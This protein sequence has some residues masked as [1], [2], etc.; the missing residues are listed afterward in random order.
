MNEN[1]NN[2]GFPIRRISLFPALNIPPKDGFDATIFHTN[3]ARKSFGGKKI[4][5]KPLQDQQN[6]NQNGEAH[7]L[8]CF[9]DRAR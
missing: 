6:L 1:K 7:A 9:F 5:N 2:I 3:R 4:P 8:K